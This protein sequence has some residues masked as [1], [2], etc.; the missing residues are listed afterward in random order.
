MTNQQVQN[1]GRVRAAHQLLP[2]RQGYLAAHTSARG[3]FNESGRWEAVNGRI[4]ETGFFSRDD[5]STYRLENGGNTLI[6]NGINGT[7]TW[8]RYSHNPYHPLNN[9][10]N[11]AEDEGPATPGMLDFMLLEMQHD[12]KRNEALAALGDEKARRWV[13][14]F[15]PQIEFHEKTKRENMRKYQESRPRYPI[16]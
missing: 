6:V 1:V 8:K 12:L 9:A 11:A 15:K 3:S 10:F 2:N 14:T 16:D 4:H 5:W 7:I 13:A